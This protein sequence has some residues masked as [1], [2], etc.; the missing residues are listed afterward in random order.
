MR[1]KSFTLL[2]LLVV[3]A[4][5]GIILGIAL[6]PITTMIRDQYLVAA[7]THVRGML[8]S[9]K[10]RAQS[11]RSGFGVFFFVDTETQRQHAA[12]IKWA[13]NP[14]E[15]LQQGTLAGS[16]WNRYADLFNI[17]EGQ[18]Y[19]FGGSVRVGRSSNGL[20]NQQHFNN[21]VI[22]F[23][24]L[25]HLEKIPDG[26]RYAI[27]DK[28][29]DENRTGD[30]TNL[31]VVDINDY[32]DSISSQGTIRFQLSPNDPIENLIKLDSD[33]YSEFDNEISLRVYDHGD[34][35]DLIDFP[36]EQETY[37]AEHATTIYVGKYG[38]VLVCREN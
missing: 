11:T 23:S 19:T 16:Y 24:P 18:I 21:F 9:A 7:I 15:H 36:S 30:I 13:G 8:I 10:S 26:Y 12:M 37:L 2:E 1:L 31:Q 6:P 35:T 20:I 27:T 5:I 3:I 14:P 34:L 38:D 33:R 17:V 29:E 22:I 28:D 25:R 32:W 4:I